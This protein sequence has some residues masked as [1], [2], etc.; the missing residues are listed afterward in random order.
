MPSTFP[1]P[2]AAPAYNRVRLG[3]GRTFD[4]LHR[5]SDSAVSGAAVPVAAARATS[6][7]YV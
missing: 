7:V 6:H 1:T 5:V 3:I 2:R 4:S